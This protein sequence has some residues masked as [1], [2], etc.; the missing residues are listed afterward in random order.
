MIELPEAMI[1]ARQMTEELKG[2]KVESCIRGNSPHKFAFYNRPPEEYEAILK[3]KTMGPAIEQGSSIWASVEP[4]YV[5]LL[6]W[7]GE[8]ILFHQNESTLP[9]KHQLLL[10]FEDNTYLTVTVQ[11]W[12]FA[13]SFTNPKLKEK[14][15]IIL[16]ER[17]FLL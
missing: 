2:K 16:A 7:G 4:D 11:G 1:I 13:H 17:R 10:H 6:G 15:D 3:G 14:G 5:L 9:K 8:R 12:G